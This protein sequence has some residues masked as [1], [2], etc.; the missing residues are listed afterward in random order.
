MRRYFDTWMFCD[1]LIPVMYV[2]K[3]VFSTNF[4][5]KEESVHVVCLLHAHPVT[6]SVAICYSVMPREVSCLSG[7]EPI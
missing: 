5:L 4:C 1:S 3:S 6:C 7:L 2:C